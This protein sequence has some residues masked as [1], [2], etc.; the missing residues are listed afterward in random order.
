MVDDR[1]PLEIMS[2]SEW[3]LAG[4]VTTPAYL[5]RTGKSLTLV[6]SFG[7][8]ASRIWAAKN[9]KSVVPKVEIHTPDGIV[10]LVNAQVLG[11]VPHVGPSSAKHSGSSSSEEWTAVS[12]SFRQ[13]EYTSGGG[14]SASDSWDDWGPG[15]KKK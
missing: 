5:L 3:R 7:T 12:F 9:L 8:L 2:P 11:V 13:I 15:G 6:R 14:A 4:S 1:L 10:T